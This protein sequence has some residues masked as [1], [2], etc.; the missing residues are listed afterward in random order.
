GL[1]SDMQGPASTAIATSVALRLLRRLGAT[2]RQP[3]VVGALD[4][5][6][7]TLDRDLGVWWIVGPDVNDAP[8]APWWHWSADAI[9]SDS[10]AGAQRGFVWNPSAELLGQLYAYREKAPA[11]VIEIVEARLRAEIAALQVIESAY[12]LK[13]AV[14]LAETPEAPADLVEALDPLIHRSLAAQDP[15]DEHGP[16][17]DY[18]AGPN[19]RYAD[20]VAPR[21]DA[22]IAALLSQQDDDG[23][24]KL[25]WEW[26][27]VDAAAWAKAK[28][29]ARGWVT[30]EALETLR[31][32][33]RIES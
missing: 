5:L 6:G 23:G 33:G 26:G 2:A 1:E 29:D 28:R 24:W 7:E 14:R 19:S 21:V 20:A 32:W 25:F 22:A 11:G 12:D 27:F 4:W 18:A 10:L 13:C 9:G 31:A 30:R 8:R 16:A 3:M 15:A 17:L